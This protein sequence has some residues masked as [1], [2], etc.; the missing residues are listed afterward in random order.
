MW[1]QGTI[2]SPKT[3][4]EYKYAIKHYEEC[5]K[6]GINNGRIS[7]LFIHTFDGN[8]MLCAY[9]RGWDIRPVKKVKAIYNMIIAE[10]N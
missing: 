6:Y 1:T 7:K 3:G 2:T 9:D 5:S 8:H 10:C 4:A